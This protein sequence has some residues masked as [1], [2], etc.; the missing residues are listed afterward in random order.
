MTLFYGHKPRLLLNFDNSTLNNSVLV[1]KPEVS[2]AFYTILS[3]NKAFYT[4]SSHNP[5]RMYIDISVIDKLT[6]QQ[7]KNFTINVYRF[8]IGD[9][10]FHHKVVENDFYRKMAE[11]DSY[12]LVKS[13]NAGPFEPFYE[14]YGGDFYYRSIILDEMF[15]VGMYL[16]LV[17]LK[18]L[19]LGIPLMQLNRLYKSKQNFSIKIFHQYSKGKL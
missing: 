12:H 14:E 18:N 9:N 10:D 8:A 1:T 13:I 4:V 19:L 5:F 16:L 7:E 17:I 2:Q 11:N 6:E 3:N 15:P